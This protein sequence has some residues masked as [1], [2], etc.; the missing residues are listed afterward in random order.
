MFHLWK[1]ISSAWEEFK[2]R[3]EKGEDPKKILDDLNISGTAAGACS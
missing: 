1:P 2:A 3:R